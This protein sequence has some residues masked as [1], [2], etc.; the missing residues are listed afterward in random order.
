[1]SRVAALVLVLAFRIGFR[2]FAFVGVFCCL[3]L[4]LPTALC[5]CDLALAGYMPRASKRCCSPHRRWQHLAFVFST[6]FVCPLRRRHYP[7]C[8]L[9]CGAQV[10]HVGGHPCRRRDG[11]CVSCGLFPCRLPPL[12]LLTQI[13]L[14]A[15]HGSCLRGGP[16]SLHILLGREHRGGIVCL[17]RACFVCTLLQQG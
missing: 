9:S 14:P 2:S 8:W 6:S 10:L 4:R 16:S 5:R 15:L 3:R 17:A 13:L 11:W 12:C 1:M 7:W